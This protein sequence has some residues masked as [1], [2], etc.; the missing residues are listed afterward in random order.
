MKGLACMKLFLKLTSIPLLVCLVVVPTFGEPQASKPGKENQLTSNQLLMRD[1][2]KQ[3]NRILEGITLNKFDQV[4]DGA[5]TLGMISRAA[6][7]HISDP[8]PRYQRLSKNFQEEATDLERHAKDRNTDAAT[9]D[10]VRMN[11]T[12]AQCH[13]HMRERTDERQ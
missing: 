4:E 3:M 5:K 13:Q 12:C 11:V 8:T 2:L 7:W 1:K 10:L 9:L 6:S